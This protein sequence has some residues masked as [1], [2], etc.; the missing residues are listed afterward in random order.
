[1]AKTATKKAIGTIGSWFAT[2]EGKKLPCVHKHWS[3]PWPNYNDPEARP[4][5]LDFDDLVAAIKETGVAI[6]QKDKQPYKNAEDK[7]VLMRDGYIAVFRIDKESIF[8][9]QDGLRFRFI[10]RVFD[11]A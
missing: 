10:D 2:V 7:T 3:T 5:I 1:M 6:L 4:G 8:L 11:L 9:D